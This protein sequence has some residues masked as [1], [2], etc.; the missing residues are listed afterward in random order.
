[1]RKSAGKKSASLLGFF[2]GDGSA[3]RA[4]VGICVALERL[5]ENQERC[6]LD[7]HRHAFIP[8]RSLRGYRRSI[9]TARRDTGTHRDRHFLE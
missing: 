2:S 8:K 4:C 9:G 3:E 6:S 5:R 1:V 7:G